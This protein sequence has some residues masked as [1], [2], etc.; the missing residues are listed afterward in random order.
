MDIM[1]A[2]TEIIKLN[3]EFPFEIFR[4]VGFSQEDIASGRAYWHNH[5]CLE[6][7]YILSSGGTYYIG[8]ETYPICKG[9]IFIINNYEYHYAASENG[10]ME[11]M[12]IVFDPNLV[13]QND[14]M[15]FQ[16]IK[17]FYEWKDGFKHRIIVDPKADG[18]IQEALKEMET[19]WNNRATGYKLVTKSL[20]LKLLAL[21]YRRFESTSQ[22]SE[23]VKRFQNEYIRI[24]DA[25]N[26][27]DEHLQEPLKLSELAEMVHMNSNYF[28]G[29]FKN[30]TGNTV[31]TYI[32]KKRLHYACLRLT[33][34]EDSIIQVASDSGFPNVSYFN[35]TFKKY[36][37]VT[38]HEYRNSQ[39]M[40]T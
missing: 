19:E 16:Y 2:I 38:P 9:D 36:L 21:L 37:G 30:C 18:N 29:F 28:S 20:L 6:L 24:I 17:A 11:M 15:D 12:V 35:R 3:Q 7:N 26:Y 32:I 27:I 40:H 4:G 39:T 25:V 23:K 8:D 22:Y 13:W 34:S 14:R 1:R 10:D 5:A 33:T 31:S